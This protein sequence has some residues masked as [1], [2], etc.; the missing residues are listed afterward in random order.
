MSEAEQKK[1][2]KQMKLDDMKTPAPPKETVKSPKP[3]A[4]KPTKSFGELVDSDSE[5]EKKKKVAKSKPKEKKKASVDDDDDGKD[6]A[7]SDSQ[8]DETESEDEKKKDDEESESEEESAYVSPTETSESDAVT[9]ESKASDS[10]EENSDE[11]ESEETLELKI[12]EKKLAKKKALSKK[13]KAKEGEKKKSKKGKREASPPPKKKK[14]PADKEKEETKKKSKSS[15][16][17]KETKKHV[18]SQSPASNGHEEKPKAAEASKHDKAMQLDEKKVE[19]ASAS[20]TTTALP[21]EK[22]IRP[23][24][25]AKAETT[26]AE[27]SPKSEYDKLVALAVTKRDTVVSEEEILAYMQKSQQHTGFILSAFL[28]EY[29]KCNEESLMVKA[30]ESML[31]CNTAGKRH[32]LMEFDATTQATRYKTMR[33]M[34]VTLSRQNNIPVPPGTVRDEPLLRTAEITE[35][36]LLKKGETIKS[37]GEAKWE[38]LKAELEEQRKVAQTENAKYIAAYKDLSALEKSKYEFALQELL[39]KSILSDVGLHCVVPWLPKVEIPNV[40]LWVID[41]QNDGNRTTFPLDKKG[42][43]EFFDPRLFYAMIKTCALPPLDNEGMPGIC[44]LAFG[45]WL[46]DRLHTLRNK[47]VDKDERARLNKEI[48]DFQTSLFYNDK[49]EAKLALFKV[50]FPKLELPNAEWFDL[51]ANPVWVREA[52]DLPDRKVPR[53]KQTPGR[54]RKASDDNETEET[55]NSDGDEGKTASSG[56]SVP[57]PV[58]KQEEKKPAEPTPEAPQPAKAKRGGRKPNA[59]KVSNIESKTRETIVNDRKHAVTHVSV[60]ARVY[61][62]LFFIDKTNAP[63]DKFTK[64]PN[65]ALILEAG[66]RLNELAPTRT[67]NEAKQRFAVPTLES[68]TTSAHTVNPKKK[69]AAAAKGKKT[70]RR[71]KNDDD[72][73]EE[74]EDEDDDDQSSTDSEDSGNGCEE[75]AIDTKRVSQP[76]EAEVDIIASLAHLEKSR[77]RHQFFEWALSDVA[78]EIHGDC[79]ALNLKLTQAESARL[80]VAKQATT[81]VS[82]VAVATVAKAS[83]VPE[84]IVRFKILQ[85]FDPAKALALTSGGV[86]S[87]DFALSADKEALVKEHFLLWLSDNEDVPVAPDKTRTVKKAAITRESQRVHRPARGTLTMAGSMLDGTAKMSTAASNAWLMLKISVQAIDPTAPLDTAVIGAI[88]KRLQLTQKLDR[89]AIVRVLLDESKMLDYV[90]KTMDKKFTDGALVDSDVDISNIPWMGR[91]IAATSTGFVSYVANCLIM[92]NA[93]SLLGSFIRQGKSSPEEIKALCDAILPT[94]PKETFSPFMVWEKNDADLALKP[95]A[96]ALRL[97]EKMLTV[98]T[99]A[100]EQVKK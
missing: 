24:S 27:S 5:E 19:T 86:D 87:T 82:E 36:D 51:K 3:V 67:L 99:P 60:E 63:D 61:P 85:H 76:S 37:I 91:Q 89:G 94:L 53:G 9:T 18:P 41:G 2:K 7:S 59:A 25:K 13:R 29:V 48:E 55:K 28:A 75:M 83:G 42:S 26:A 6:V 72:D 43:G 40:S 20:A 66:D 34:T 68:H 22:P 64:L 10:S 46:V 17:S 38:V 95:G 39:Q 31:K 50:I 21:P 45:H 35:K 73:D 97:A 54:K 49:V 79:L 62:Q 52:G 77:V 1:E 93:L 56:P 4:A 23:G 57:E 88:L 84:A 16:N 32:K 70:R 15:K 30:A 65:Q 71:K 14:K 11:D 12:L 44:V 33:A 98:A 74:E 78:N 96:E 47:K 58:Q 100:V 81:I 69:A 90:L 80:A 8:T 92:L